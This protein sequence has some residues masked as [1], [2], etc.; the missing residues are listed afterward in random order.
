MLFN[1]FVFFIFLA[2][3][4]LTYYFLTPRLR[5]YFLVFTSFIFYGFWDYRFTALLLLIPIA[6]FVVGKHIFLAQNSR[7]K[8]KF[9]LISLG[10]NLTILFFFK[11]FNFFV[12]SVSSVLVNFNIQLDYLHINLILPLGISF[13]IFKSLTYTIDIYRG[14][15]K[16]AN[17]FSD[18]L[19]FVSFFPQLL[20]GPIERAKI[21]L[22]QILVM[23]KPTRMQINQGFAL[24][25]S[26]MIK[27]VLIGDTAGKIVDQ[28]FI[29]PQYY[30]S[31]ELL[32]ALVLFSIQ[33]YADFSGYSQ[34]A[35]GVAKW[36]GFETTI[37][38]N[39]PYLS[40]N[41]TEFW[42][43]WHISLSLW[44]RDYLFLPI[45]YSLSR[46]IKSR[47]FW[48]IPQDKLVYSLATLITFFVCGLWHG[49]N[50]TFA[51]WG[52]LHGVYLS[53]NKFFSGKKNPTR[54]FQLKGI[55]SLIRF[56]FGVVSTYFIVCITWLLFRVDSLNDA[57][58]FLNRMMNW[59]SGNFDQRIIRI[60]ISFILVSFIIDALEYYFKEHEYWLKLKAEYRFGLALV[61][62]LLIF[63]CMLQSAPSPFIYFQF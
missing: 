49:A 41:I 5:K 59:E 53:C 63:L 29:Q 18:Y 52:L 30:S 28:I 31:S 42:K 60:S 38:F 33:I 58:Y 48:G 25:T 34:I 1:S 37:N 50:W 40:Q 55:S 15:L 32:M 4:V 24:I 14:E 47:R 35:R 13:Y 10:F 27:K 6:D 54:S 61:S 51:I 16:P 22:P 26:G 43:R 2:G 23:N 3:V 62:W 12:S 11:Y 45:A 56:L 21:M 57:I 39:Q 17:S 46:R 44:F 9:L 8:K 7:V 20:A 19:L 36:F